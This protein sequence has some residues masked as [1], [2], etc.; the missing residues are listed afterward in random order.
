MYSFFQTHNLICTR[1][2][3]PCYKEACACAVW[4]APLLS[5]CKKNLCYSHG[6]KSGV[7]ASRSYLYLDVYLSVS[8]KTWADQEGVQRVQ[9]TPRLPEKSQHI[10]FFSNTGP[11]P[12]EKIQSYQASINCQAIISPSAI[13]HLKAF[14]WRA[15]VGPFIV[16][17]LYLDPLS[18]HQIKKRNVIKFGPHP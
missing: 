2:G 15:D 5:T 3:K 8:S 9:T 10:W 14:R 12:D 7:L 6:T 16:V 17:H 11:D 4:S 18:L 1:L 13:R